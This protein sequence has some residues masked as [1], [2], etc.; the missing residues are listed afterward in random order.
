MLL[1]G[2]ALVAIQATHQMFEG[3]VRQ[4]AIAWQAED[5]S[6][7]EFVKAF[8]TDIDVP[9]R[10]DGYA[11]ES[12]Q[13]S[14]RDTLSR[15][16]WGREQDA[17]NTCVEPRRAILEQRIGSS[18]CRSRMVAFANSTLQLVCQSSQAYFPVSAYFCP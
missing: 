15:I 12:S 16:L 14:D 9:L 13:S 18:V 7:Y 4:P 1:K 3:N 11:A 5:G 2:R 6:P 10:S 17:L 8:C